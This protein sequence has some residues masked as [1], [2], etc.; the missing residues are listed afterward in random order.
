[1][2]IDS[3]IPVLDLRSEEVQNDPFAVYKRLRQHQPIQPV[4]GTV[5]GDGLLATRYED[6]QTIL[7]DKRFCNDRRRAGHAMEWTEAWWAPQMVKSFMESMSS[8]DDPDHSRLRGLAHQAFTPRRVRDIES[9]LESLCHELLDNA[10]EQDT[11]DLVESYALPVP[12]TI[13]SEMMGVPHKD[14]ANFRKWSSDFLSTNSSNLLDL[15]NQARNGFSM[16][17]YFK[18]LIKSKRENPQDDLTTALVEARFEDEQLSESELVVMLFVLLMAGHETTV[19]LISTGTFAFLTHPEELEKLK[20]NPD[21]METGI[22]EILRWAGPSHVPA[23]RY[24]LEDVEL[25]GVRIPAGTRI[26]PALASANRDEDAFD[27]PDTFDITRQPKNKHV[28]LGMG[29]HYCLGAPLARLEAST[30]LHILF[31]R[32]PDLQLAARP[33][34]LPWSNSILVRGITELPVRWK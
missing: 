6:V 34:G 25:S 24:T 4:T 10:T 13:I 23:P 21:L 8:V 30:A 20:A 27:N 12:M 5:L 29:A 18:K 33:D 7:K 28:A 3:Q 19:N 1:M 2:M 16:Y 22:E 26:Y 9:R 32:C 31:E 14:R 11:F 15:L 17:R